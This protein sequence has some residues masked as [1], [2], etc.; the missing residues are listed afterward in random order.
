METR[1]RSV[2]KKIVMATG[3]GNDFCHGRKVVGAVGQRDAHAANSTDGQGSVG[4][5]PQSFH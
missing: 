5:F 4:I 3:Y 1:Y 2:M